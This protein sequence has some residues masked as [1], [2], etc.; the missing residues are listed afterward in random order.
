M[1]YHRGGDVSP[2][3]PSLPFPG[4]EGEHKRTLVASRLSKRLRMHNLTTF[5]EYIKFLKDDKSDTEIV[6]FINAVTTNKTDF[7]RENKHFE[8]MRSTFLPA[9]EKAHKE[10]LVDNLRIWSAACSSGEEP[11]S[12]LITLYEYFGSNM[13]KYDIKVLGTDIDTSVLEHAQ[14]G[15]FREDVV[16]PISNSMLRKYFLRGKGD[17]SNRYKVKDFLKKYIVFRQLNFKDKDYDIHTKFDLV[18][19]RNVIIY[20]DKEF[21]KSLFSRLYG[22]MKHNAYIFIGHSE[23]LFGVSEQFK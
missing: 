8:F 11:Y 18:F 13:D 20:F 12:I 22:Y 5:S 3:T 23:T 15:I 16:S 1:C 21:Q 6:D 14:V 10:G 9:W 19:C 4:R 17:N 7:F 2:I